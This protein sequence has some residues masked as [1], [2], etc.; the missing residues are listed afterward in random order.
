MRTKIVLLI[1]GLALFFF[2]ACIKED[3]TTLPP[4][5]QSGKNTFG[6]YVNGELF[7]RDISYWFSYAPSRVQYNPATKMLSISCSGRNEM[8]TITLEVLNPEVNIK[9]T[10][11]SV[12][13]SKWI[14][15]KEER[16]AENRTSQEFAVITYKGEN[17]GEILLTR[18]DIANGIVS[19]TFGCE[20]PWCENC[21]FAPLSLIGD[22]TL[23]I[24]QG[25][26]DL[27]GIEHY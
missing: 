20:I 16:I 15:L 13:H 24:T 1:I 9:K 18:F 7:L 21:D 10:L 27:R 19:G 22:S 23:K 2:N 5:T 11:R 26:F 4:E 3:L 6:C 8:G 17:T 12:K 25:R 14:V